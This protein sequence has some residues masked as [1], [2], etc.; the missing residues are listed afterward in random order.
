MRLEP[1]R[2]R[3]D[4]RGYRD[5]QERPMNRKLDSKDRDLR[6]ERSPV[7]RNKK[8]TGEEV[9]ELRKQHRCYWCFQDCDVC[10]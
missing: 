10:K 3:D 9:D 2:G 8:L 6:R 7:P 5:A 1:Q 4:R